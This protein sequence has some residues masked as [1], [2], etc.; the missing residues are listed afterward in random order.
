ME[1]RLNFHQGTP[2]ELERRWVRKK[3]PKKKSIGDSRIRS[4]LR[5]VR[6]SKLWKGGKKGGSACSLVVLTRRWIRNR[7][8]KKKIYIMGGGGSDDDFTKKTKPPKK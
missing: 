8:L 5:W 3:K 1:T 4:W 2:P 6:E 7:H